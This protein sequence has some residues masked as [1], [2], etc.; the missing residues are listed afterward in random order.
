MSPV[1]Q[2]LKVRMGEINYQGHRVTSKGKPLQ[3]RCVWVLGMKQ[4]PFL[5]GF[6]GLWPPR[7]ILDLLYL[8]MPGEDEKQAL[9]REGHATG[10]RGS[11]LIT[12]GLGH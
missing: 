7:V 2:E 12:V 4:R 1:V 6:R 5:T 10:E 8:F 11:S 3:E 9:I